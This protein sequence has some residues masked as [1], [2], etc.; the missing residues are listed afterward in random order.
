MVPAAAPVASLQSM[1]VHRSASVPRGHTSF[2]P[3]AFCPESRSAPWRERAV[4][5]HS[6]RVAVR[7]VAVCSWSPFPDT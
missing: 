1:T 6:F 3:Q 2:V 5:G 4:L 7:G